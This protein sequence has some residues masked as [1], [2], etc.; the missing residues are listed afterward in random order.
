MA[1][2]QRPYIPNPKKRITRTV[3]C[4]ECRS[5]TVT[6]TSADG[7]STINS[8]PCDFVIKVAKNDALEFITRAFYLRSTLR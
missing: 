2:G 1:H 8:I 6:D 7:S 4:A 5:I 3:T